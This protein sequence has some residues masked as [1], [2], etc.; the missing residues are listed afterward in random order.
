MDPGAGPRKP[1]DLFHHM[2]GCLV[3]KNWEREKG[4]P[5]PS[6]GTESLSPGRTNKSWELRTPLFSDKQRHETGFKASHSTNTA[7]FRRVNNLFARRKINLA[8]TKT[9]RAAAG[10]RN[11]NAFYKSGPDT[12]K[13]FSSTGKYQDSG[14]FLYLQRGWESGNLC[15]IET[16]SKP[17][18]SRL[19]GWAVIFMLAA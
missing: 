16:R 5:S 14:A 17:A 4:S 15:C 18:S 9:Q 12:R 11:L 19:Q 2:N 10:V 7:L 8:Q 3:R 1:R 6:T 13:E